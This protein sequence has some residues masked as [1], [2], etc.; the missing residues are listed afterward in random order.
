[1]FP[2]LRVSLS[3]SKVLNFSTEKCE[4]QLAGL[5]KVIQLPD[6]KNNELPRQSTNC[7]C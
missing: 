7:W 4:A 2:A 6:M 1:M 3:V 5:D